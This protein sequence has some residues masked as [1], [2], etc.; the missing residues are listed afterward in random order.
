MP[1]EDLPGRR[2]RRADGLRDAEHH[3]ADQRAPQAA[4]AADDHRFEREDQPDRT[5]RR[6]EVGADGNSTPAIAVKIIAMPSAT[7]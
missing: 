2:Q 7:A 5:G 6:I 4:E 1:G 3:A